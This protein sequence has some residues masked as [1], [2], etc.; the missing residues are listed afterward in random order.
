MPNSLQPVVSRRIDNGIELQLQFEDKPLFL[1]LAQAEP[2][3]ELI[4]QWLDQARFSEGRQVHVGQLE[5]QSDIE[6]ELYELM[7]HTQ[8]QD[9]VVFFCESMAIVSQA[10]Q[11]VGFQD[12]PLS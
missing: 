7:S 8:P 11:A 2:D 10:L 3:F 6:D 12:A 5:A 9:T 1:V 4:P